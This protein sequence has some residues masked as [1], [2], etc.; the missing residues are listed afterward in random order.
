MKIKV[1]IISI[2]ILLAFVSG[3]VATS[4]PIDIQPS[5]K[6]IEILKRI[7]ELQKTTIGLHDS[8]PSS[9]SKDRA[10]LI[11]KFTLVANDAVHSSATGWQDTVKAGW[12][13]LNEQLKTNIKL[14]PELQMIW[15]LVDSLVKGLM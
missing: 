12:I 5:I 3:C 4:I 10:D 7:E 9:L 11:I 1:R 6:R 15:N 8:S 2:A 14:E 13:T